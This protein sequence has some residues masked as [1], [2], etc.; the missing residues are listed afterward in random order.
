MIMF[1][2]VFFPHLMKA[3]RNISAMNEFSGVEKERGSRMR[4]KK[5]VKPES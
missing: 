1:E 4:D 5:L 3:K 2:R